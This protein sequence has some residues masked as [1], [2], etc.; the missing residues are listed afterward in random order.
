MVQLLFDSKNRYRWWLTNV[1]HA[2]FIPIW[3]LWSSWVKHVRMDRII[4]PKYLQL[5][6]K[7]TEW[8]TDPTDLF[9]QSTGENSGCQWNIRIQTCPE[10][11][12]SCIPACESVTVTIKCIWT[13]KPHH[14]FKARIKI[15]IVLQVLHKNSKFCSGSPQSITW[16]RRIYPFFWNETI[17][18]I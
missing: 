13:A 8:Q 11:R 1:T 14:P 9:F 12:G 15:W 4:F 17:S 16:F 7:L 5:W 2:L 10:A 18:A 3:N 6:I